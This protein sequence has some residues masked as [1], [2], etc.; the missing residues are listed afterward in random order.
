M[1][2]YLATGLVLLGLLLVSQLAFTGVGLAYSPAWSGPTEVTAVADDENLAAVAV[3]GGTVAWIAER[4]GTWQVQAATVETENESVRIDERWTAARSSDPLSDLDV[5]ADGDRTSLVWKRSTT[6][7]VVH[8]R[9]SV[10]EARVVSTDPVRLDEPSVGL[11]PGGAVAAWQFYE[12]GRTTVR[13]VS[14]PADGEP[15]YGRINTSTGGEDAPVVTTSGSDVTVVWLDTGRSD[16]RAT[17]VDPTDG[18]AVGR[19]E[20]LGA[21]RPGGGFGGSTAIAV[22]ADRNGSTVR[23]AWTHGSGVDTAAVGLTDGADGAPVRTLGEGNHP[24][25]AVDGDRWVGAWLYRARTSG[26]DLAAEVHGGGD[27]FAGTVSQLPSTADQARATFAPG[28]SVVWIERGNGARVLAGAYLGPR[29]AGPLDRLEAST[30]RFLFIALGAA[31]L[32]AVTTPVMPWSFVTLLG[33]FLVS[34][35]LVTAALARAVVTV[36]GPV[37]GPTDADGLRGRLLDGPTAAYGLGFAVVQIAVGVLVVETSRTV[38]SLGFSHPLEAGALALVAAVAVDRL[39][40]LDSAW[41]FA[42]VAAV[43][44]NAALWTTAMPGFL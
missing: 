14:L 4:N 27:A 8:Y 35:R 24:A 29:T 41:R 6:A 12:D 43:T 42:A 16:V 17:A 26:W 13:V 22:A 30:G 7:E 37:G 36:T 31:V 3:D 40:E 23:A 15:T 39:L 5:A 38:G 1:R 33:A 25:V 34:T 9:R 20:T 11:V 32:G 18:V 28:P 44:Y 21:A 19:T 10:D 2:R